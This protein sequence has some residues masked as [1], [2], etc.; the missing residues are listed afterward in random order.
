MYVHTGADYY[1]QKMVK[2][3]VKKSNNTSDLSIYYPIVDKD[4]KTMNAYLNSQTVYTDTWS[5]GR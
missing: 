4:Y 1:Y 3:L 5:P 2:Q